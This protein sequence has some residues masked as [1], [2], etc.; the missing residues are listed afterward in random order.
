MMIRKWDDLPIAMR[1]E[2]VRSYYDML[3]RKKA[4]LFMKRGFDL[5]LS[6]LL[7]FILSPVFLLLIIL[8]KLDSPGPVFFRQVRI[9]SYG[10]PFRIF[11]FRTMVCDAPE[12]GP[13]ITVAQDPRITKAGKILR[14]FH[15]DE[16]CQL[17]NVF[18]GDM[19][20]VGTRPEVPEYVA[21]YTPEMWATLLLPAGITSHASLLYRN[22]AAQ[23]NAAESP[24]QVYLE[25]I[26][27]EKMKYNLEDILEFSLRRDIVILFQTLYAV[28]FK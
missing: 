7:L 24:E 5:V 27:P 14:R 11:K 12:R 25:K 26:L 28:F 6:S 8:I 9:T 21:A 10:R 23:L 16:L 20:F 1:S 18:Q 22:E 15:L 4:S 19:S 3:C 2:S 13:S 17:L